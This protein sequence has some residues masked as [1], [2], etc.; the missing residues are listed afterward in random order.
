MPLRLITAGESHGRGLV[1]TVEGLPAGLAV[2]EEY[3]N[4]Q[5]RRRQAGYGR[6]GRMRI[7]QDRAEIL[8]GLVDGVTIGAPVSVLVWNRD[9]RTGEAPL[10]RPRPGHADLVGAQK[11]GFDDVRRALERASAR[12]TAARVAGATLARRLL[13]E[14]GI[15]V[16]SHVVELGGV[17][18]ADL[19]PDWDEVARRAETSDLRCADPHAAQAMHRAIDEAKASGDTLGGVIEIVAV[20]VPPGLGSYVHWDR[21][22]DGRIAQAVMSVHAIKG[23][24]IGDAFAIASGRGST[25]HDEI[26]YDAARGFYR[27]TNRAGG[28]EGGVSNG[29]PIVVRAAMKPL[30]TLRAPLRSV[31]IR[32]REPAAAAVV[33]SDVTALPAAGVVCEA[34]LAFVLA[35][36]LCEKFGAD[37]L[38]DMRGAYD[39]YL[40]RIR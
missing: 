26:H 11:Y 36:A 1:A 5:L 6:G 16:L 25:A 14:F 20:G 22:L 27:E 21:R 3:L 2:D 18:V 29:M 24:A 13:E 8:S 33:R 37:S 28:I 40:Q 15:R 7:E 30:S 35:D 39:R 17:H 38:D 32:T 9:W 4:G 19:P 12:E 31:D 34:M 23:V 10:V